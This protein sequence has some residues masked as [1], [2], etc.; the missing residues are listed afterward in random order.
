M[1]PAKIVRPDDDATV[2]RGAGDEYRYL[3]TGADTS[4][5]YFLMEAR[6]PPGGGPPPHVQTREDEGFYILEGN[7]TFWLEGREIEAGPGTF[8][9][10]PTGAV[11]NFRNGT[12]QDARMLILF[13]PAG[14]EGMFSKMGADPERYVEIA[15]EYGVTFPD[16]AVRFPDTDD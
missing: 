1:S 5:N 11:H 15:N 14:I 3:A 13:A 6:V 2:I 8:L 12:D 10:V 7:V 4:G 9:Q 16:T